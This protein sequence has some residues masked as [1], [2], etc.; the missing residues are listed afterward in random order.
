MT[1][2]VIV[3]RGIPGSGKTTWVKQ[4]LATHSPGT[5]VRIS[6][7]DLSHMLYG[8]AWGTFFLS[9]DT[10]ETLHN[11]RLSML[12]TF[13]RQD[14]ITHV[15]IDNTNLAVQTVR[16]LQDV[17]LQHGADFIVDDSFLAVDIDICILRDTLRD[18]PVGADVIRKMAGN[19]RK[20]KPWKATNVPTIKK[21]DNDQSGRPYAVIVDI[22]GTLAHMDGRSPYDYSLVHTDIVDEGV[23]FVVNEA[24]KKGDVIIA[25]GRNDDSMELTEAWLKDNDVKYTNI[26]MR[27][28]GDVRPDWVVK[29]EIFQERIAGRYRIR[30]VLDDRDQVVELWRNKLGLPTYQ[31]AEG[32]F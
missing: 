18:S 13:L 32:D 2:T 17:A 5:A 23:K 15:Y 26:Y 7:D 12:K 25:S 8:Q 24:F 19:A 22:D 1:K 28:T 30:F 29:N 10:K 31:V 6:N 3:P 4:Q 9:D 20:L 16:A 21:Y 11:L 27:K 14:A